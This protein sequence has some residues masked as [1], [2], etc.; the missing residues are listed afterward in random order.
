METIQASQQ[1]KSL[2]QRA[3]GLIKELPQQHQGRNNWLISYGESAEAIALR[4]TQSS[5]NS[6]PSTYLDFEPAY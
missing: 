5:K 1:S 6:D 4:K 3:E 2:L